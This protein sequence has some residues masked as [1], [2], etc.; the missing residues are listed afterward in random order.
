MK[1]GA[2]RDE[3][4]AVED[5]IRELGFTPNEMPGSTRLA[6][7]I[8]G[9]QGPLDPGHVQRDDR[10][11]RGGADLE[12]V[13]AGVARGEA[14]RHRRSR[15]AARA[16][17]RRPL[18][19]H[20]RAVRGREPRADRQAA[21][22]AVKA[23][24]AHF[25]RGGAF[26]PR[27]SPYAFQGMKEEGLKIARRGARADRPADRHRGDGHARRRAG[28]ALRRR[29]ADRRAQHAELL[30]AGGGGRAAARR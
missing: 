28:R 7:G 4:A 1:A 24:G 16:V 19:R 2:T 14:R 3:V 27:T 22:A 6:I 17:R 5:R 26:K 13:E 29:A 18:R 10:R 25:L 9:N 30:A 20:R 15:S 11:R 23:A 21:A 12:A 8:T